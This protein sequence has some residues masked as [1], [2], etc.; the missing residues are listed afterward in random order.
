[1]I[2]TTTSHNNNSNTHNHCNDNLTM[3]QRQTG[4]GF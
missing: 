2:I 4:A 3:C 1:M